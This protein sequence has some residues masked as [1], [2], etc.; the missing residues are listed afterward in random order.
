[1]NAVTG[2]RFMNQKAKREK[3]FRGF[4]WGILVLIVVVVVLLVMI[5]QFL[6]PQNERASQFGKNSAFLLYNQADFR[7]MKRQDLR[8]IVREAGEVPT[9]EQNEIF[10]QNLKSAQAKLSVYRE[11]G[12]RADRKAYSKLNKAKSGRN[13]RGEALLVN[14]NYNRQPYGSPVVTLVPG[15]F[16]DRGKYTTFLGKVYNG[17]SIS[18]KAAGKLKPGDR[19]RL[20]VRENGKRMTFHVKG[21]LVVNGEGKKFQNCSLKKLADGRYYLF[22]QDGTRYN[23]Y[24]DKVRFYAL[25]GAMIGNSDKQQEIDATLLNSTK[26]PGTYNTMIF[27]RKGY[28]TGIYNFK[29]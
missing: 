29:D 5:I 25:R 1:M 17:V 21:N 2:G 7:G 4:L 9:E 28:V 24:Y 14:Y 18:A 10:K 16:R 22:L 11:P 23:V 3:K 13:L 12:Q 8:A 6:R 27:D 15:S 20:P 26:N 19:L